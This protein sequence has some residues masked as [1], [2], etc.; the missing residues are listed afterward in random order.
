VTGEDFYKLNVPTSADG[1]HALRRDE[2]NTFRSRFLEH[3]NDDFNT[4]GAVGVLHELASTI[5][6]LADA[7]KLDNSAMA[8]AT[9]KA[10]F[11]EGVKLMKELGNVL[12]LFLEAPKAAGGGDQLVDGLMKLFIDMRAE[13]RKSKNFAIAD[14][15][16]AGLNELN[17]VLEDRADGTTWSKK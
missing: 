8:D 14:R 5:N 3:M 10:D 9:A 13:A 17:V 2:F 1:K 7:G 12:G 6:R 4:G 15:S 16:R 11:V